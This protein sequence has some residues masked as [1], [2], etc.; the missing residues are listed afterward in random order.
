MLYSDNREPSLEEILNDSLV[1][2]V[3]A[4]DKICEE[5]VRALFEAIRCRVHEKRHGEVK[6]PTGVFVA[7]AELCAAV[8]HE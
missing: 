4:R 8:P 2:L 5:E 3:M 6:E 7:S 1:Q